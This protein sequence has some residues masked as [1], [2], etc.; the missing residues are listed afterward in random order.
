MVNTISPDPEWGVGLGLGVFV[1]ALTLVGVCIFLRGKT[2]KRLVDEVDLA[3][4]RLA[5]RARELLVE[6]Q[7]ELQSILRTEQEPFDPLDVVADPG[8]L[9]GPLK[10]G[11]RTIR[12]QQK[13]R[14]QFYLLLACCSVAKYLSIAFAAAVLA[15]T[16]LYILATPAAVLWQTAAW[17]AAALAG[18]GA[19]LVIVLVH[20]N[21]RIEA[22]IEAS[23]PL[24]PTS[25]GAI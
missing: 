12:R 1:V 20:L 5:E 23:R 21:T 18:F 16:S 8:R 4:A 7:V 15:A 13:I 6:L 17:S 11:L 22:S 3:Y 14:R 10:T 2:H 25:G 19:I 9:E 24:F